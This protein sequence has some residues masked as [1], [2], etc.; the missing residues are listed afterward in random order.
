MQSPTNVTGV[1]GPGAH[2]A[3]ISWTAPTSGG[4][5]PIAKY[6]V[7]DFT[8]NPFTT[9]DVVPPAPLSCTVTGLT[10]G[11]SYVFRIKA[12]NSGGDSSIGDGFGAAITG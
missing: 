12:F 11:A 3:T 6:T 4:D 7:I 1:S 8:G 9:C 2:A 5:Y 10:P